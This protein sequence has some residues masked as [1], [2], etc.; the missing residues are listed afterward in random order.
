MI[1]ADCIDPGN[2]RIDLSA[3]AEMAAFG[4]II[5]LGIVMR[6]ARRTEGWIRPFGTALLVALLLSIGLVAEQGTSATTK[7]C[8]KSGVPATIMQTSALR[9][10]APEVASLRIAG[11]IT[12]PGTRTLRIDSI[13]V[14]IS[15]VVK[16]PGA[17]AGDCSAGDYLLTANR[18]R[19]RATL[20]PGASAIF[21][22]ARIGFATNARNQDAC[23]SAT[24]SLRYDAFGKRLPVRP[25][26]CGRD[27]AW[28]PKRWISQLKPPESPPCKIKDRVSSETRK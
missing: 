6:V 16:A 1:L 24:V 14:S 23:K 25:N 11:V 12:N 3:L 15:R 5:A 20:A 26:S 7:E 17:V 19:L 4:G 8:G 28:Y 22:G 27:S 10:L 18:M 9:G 2:T 21:G 13:V